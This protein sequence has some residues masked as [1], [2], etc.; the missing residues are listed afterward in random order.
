MHIILG[1][2]DYQRIQSTEQPVLRSN[3]DIDPGAE[4]TMLGW[5]LFGRQMSNSQSVEKGFFSKTSQQ[6][7][8]RL[9]NLEA[10]GLVDPAQAMVNFHENFPQGLV[11]TEDGY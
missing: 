10:L 1:A 9:C 7:F 2:A 11:Q 8:E 4:F 6:E 5:M 3:P